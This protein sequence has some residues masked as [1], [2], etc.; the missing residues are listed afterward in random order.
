MTYFALK[1]K[2]KQNYILASMT[3]TKKVG[4]NVH[5]NSLTQVDMDLFL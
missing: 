2:T 4:T 3:L 5:N 1:G